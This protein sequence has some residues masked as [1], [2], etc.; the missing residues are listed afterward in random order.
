MC[1]HITDL[2]VHYVLLR[3]DIKNVMMGLR[4]EGNFPSPT[5]RKGFYFQGP[6][7]PFSLETL[8]LPW[9]MFEINTKTEERH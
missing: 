6:L 5:V 4:P 7:P 8:S 3:Y 2:T 1:F 9:A